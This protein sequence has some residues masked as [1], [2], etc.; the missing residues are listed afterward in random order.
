[1]RN[2]YLEI[3][4]LPNRDLLL[5][6]SPEL[7]A[8]MQDWDV[9][10][11]IRV[12]SDLLE[13][14][15]TNGQYMVHTAD[16]FGHLSEAPLVADCSWHEDNGE[17]RHFGPVWWFPNYQVQNCMEKLRDEGEVTFTFAY[18]AEDEHKEDA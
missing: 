12:L 10:D 3:K 17:L 18:D 5:K 15:W 9:N 13:P 6:A 11:D 4:I 14:C 1:M 8:E 2:D 7:K 16:D